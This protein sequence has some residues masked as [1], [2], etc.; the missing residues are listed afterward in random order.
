[1][2]VHPSLRLVRGPGGP[3][4][5]GRPR[6]G[7]LGQ[8]G[9]A[10]GLGQG[11]WARRPGPGGYGRTYGRTDV[12]TYGRTDGRT[13]KISPAFYRTSPLWCRCPKRDYYFFLR[14]FL[15]LINENLTTS[16]VDKQGMRPLTSFPSLPSSPPPTPS[17]SPPFPLSPSP[18]LPSPFNFLF[19][20]CFFSMFENNWGRT[21][22][23]TDRRTD[24]PTNRWTHPLIEM[25]GRI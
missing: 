23:Q 14:F 4:W 6:P 3:A 13:D 16:L 25:G 24:R 9:W 11:A 19:I 18:P 15:N 8:V 17:P 10:G 1:M 5:A 12:R 7:G 20:F 21:D 2:S 22:G